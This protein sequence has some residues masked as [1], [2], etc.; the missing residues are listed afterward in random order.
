MSEPSR[1]DVLGCSAVIESSPGFI[2][3]LS[4]VFVLLSISKFQKIGIMLKVVTYLV[5][6]LGLNLYQGP[7]RKSDHETCMILTR[8]SPLA[9]KSNLAPDTQ[10]D[11]PWLICPPVLEDLLP[12]ISV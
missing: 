7:S 12:M 10:H 8:K 1:S 9:A 2:D 4:S 6:K 5:N 3:R 11:H